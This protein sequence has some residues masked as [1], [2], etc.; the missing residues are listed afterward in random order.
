MDVGVLAIAVVTAP[1]WAL[2]CAV[3]A[4]A[5][6]RSVG[7]WALGGLVFGLIG[8]LCLAVSPTLAASPTAAPGQGPAD[9]DTSEAQLENLLKLLE[10]GSITTGVYEQRRAAVIARHAAAIALR[11]RAK[12]ELTRAVVDVPEAPKVTTWF[13]ENL[14]APEADTVSS[15]A[16]ESGPEERERRGGPVAVK[17]SAALVFVLVLGGVVLVSYRQSASVP[18]SGTT[19]FA[20]ELSLRLRLASDCE[21]GGNSEDCVLGFDDPSTLIKSGVEE[22]CAYVPEG[23]YWFR[24]TPTGGGTENPVVV[25]G[26]ERFDANV[27][28]SA[29]S[30]VCSRYAG[31][32]SRIAR[33]GFSSTPVS[34]TRALLSLS[35][36]AARLG[37]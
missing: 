37:H 28:W 5:K 1:L 24:A 6:N 20:D 19:Q 26:T 7:A 17:Y 11:E 25:R 9:S 10:G 21:V 3:M 16:A 34:S 22:L 18:S 31:L 8:V 14:A 2:L 35:Q 36:E 33:A 4:S 13:E 32:P 27:D 12:A 15:M 30:S 23:Y 29:F